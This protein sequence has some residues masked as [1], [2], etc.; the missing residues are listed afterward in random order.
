MRWPS[1]PDK[2]PAGR[3][4][5]R[6]SRPTFIRNPSRS[7]ISLSTRRAIALPV[8]DHVAHAL[9]EPRP[10]LIERELV[11]LRERVQCLSEVRVLAPGPRRERAAT[12][13]ALRI[14]DQTIGIDLLA[15][16]DAAALGAGAVR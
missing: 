2:V 8:Q 1:P 15:R 4:S 10:R 9:L 12:E 6:Y 14:R 16:A 5:V 13:R 7:R 11:P 3:S